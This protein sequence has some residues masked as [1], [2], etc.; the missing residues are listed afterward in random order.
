MIPLTD[1]QKA[2]EKLPKQSDVKSDLGNVGVMLGNS[3]END[4][5]NHIDNHENEVGSTSA[6]LKEN[7][8]TLVLNSKKREN[9]QITVETVRV[10]N[11]DLDSR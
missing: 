3:P 2:I 1:K 9:S 4:F 7:T 6:G 5:A 8:D 10:I 11:E